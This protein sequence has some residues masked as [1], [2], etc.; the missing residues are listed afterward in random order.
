[1]A[2]SNFMKSRPFLSCLVCTYRL[3]FH[4]ARGG[5]A[6][7]WQPR[8]REGSSLSVSTV[9]I[10]CLPCLQSQKVA[11][12]RCPARQECVITPGG[13]VTPCNPPH[14]LLVLR[15]VWLSGGRAKLIGSPQIDVAGSPASSACGLHLAMTQPGHWG[16]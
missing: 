4:G 1:M 11:W 2:A 16:G 7:W 9:S 13:L 3:S 6:P 5:R 15:S 12:H 10:P 14:Y 8:C